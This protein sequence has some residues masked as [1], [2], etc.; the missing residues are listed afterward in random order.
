MRNYEDILKH[1]RIE[2]SAMGVDGGLF[3]YNLYGKRSLRVVASNSLGWDH[4][5][6]S[7]NHRTPTWEEMC[8]VKDI[9]FEPE[10]IVIQYHPPKSQYVN[11]HDYCLHMWKEQGIEVKLPPKFMV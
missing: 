1:P 7:L 4:V 6:V 8:E 3:R 9:F 11:V 10:E 5:S 2:C